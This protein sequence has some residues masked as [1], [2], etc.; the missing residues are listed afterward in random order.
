MQFRNRSLPSPSRWSLVL[1]FTGHLLVGFEHRTHFPQVNMVTRTLT[2]EDASLPLQTPVYGWEKE[3]MQP[4]PSNTL[5]PPP[6]NYNLYAWAPRGAR[7]ELTTKTLA[8]LESK[9][10]FYTVETKAEAEAEIIAGINL[11]ELKGEA[12]DPA[13]LS[14]TKTGLASSTKPASPSKTGD[15]EMKPV[16]RSASPSKRQ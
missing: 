12:S 16:S 5:R 2:D 13:K 15:V 14:P 8:E 3:W 6:N 9:V 4:T 7:V 1:S 11:K 10:E